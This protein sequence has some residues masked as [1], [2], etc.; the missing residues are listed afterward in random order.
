MGRSCVEGI[1][2]G[3]G[4]AYAY[5]TYVLGNFS[6]KKTISESFGLISASTKII[7]ER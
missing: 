3:A 4:N 7:T 5:E 6:D 1:E 2:E